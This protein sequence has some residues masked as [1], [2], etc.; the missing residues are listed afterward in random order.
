[1][2]ESVGGVVARVARAG[3]IVDV[4]VVSESTTLDMGLP[5]LVSRGR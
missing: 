2:G 1:M 5:V 3:G 4:V